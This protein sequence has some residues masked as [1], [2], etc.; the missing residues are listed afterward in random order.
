MSLAQSPISSRT[1]PR[2]PFRQPLGSRYRYSAPFAERNWLRTAAAA[3]GGS[4]QAL[5]IKNRCSNLGSDSA[6]MLFRFFGRKKGEGSLSICASDRGSPFVA[7][8]VVLVNTDE[9]PG[10]VNKPGNRRWSPVDLRGAWKSLCR[11]GHGQR[12]AA[13]EASQSENAVALRCV[14]ACWKQL[15]TKSRG[16]IITYHFNSSRRLCSATSPG[17][18]SKRSSKPT[19]RERRS[20]ILFPMTMVPCRG[21]CQG[22]TLSEG[23]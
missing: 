5:I 21:T 19:I 2:V 14:R 1:S 23:P 10:V 4:R 8:S 6:K 12:V 15:S 16:G 22:R 11:L 13:A 17:R 9:D 3:V 18:E 7:I 20:S